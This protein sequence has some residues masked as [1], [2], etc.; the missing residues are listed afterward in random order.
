MVGDDTYIIDVGQI[1]LRYSAERAR[2]SSS[3]V[4]MA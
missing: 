4:P 1:T 3:A 2:K